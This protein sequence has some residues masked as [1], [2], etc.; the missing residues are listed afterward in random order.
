MKRRDGGV[1]GLDE[2]EGSF[3][4]DCICDSPG[5]ITAHTE[6]SSAV[7]PGRHLGW[8]ASRLLPSWNTFR[9]S[10]MMN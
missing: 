5:A 4:T 9:V 6:N 10:P 3:Y 1:E 7:F 2:D 8:L